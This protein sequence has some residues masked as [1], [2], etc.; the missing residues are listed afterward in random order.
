MQREES[1]SKL[2]FSFSKLAVKAIFYL[3]QKVLKPGTRAQQEGS[4][5]WY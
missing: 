2:C 1:T 3:L 5:T 4:E